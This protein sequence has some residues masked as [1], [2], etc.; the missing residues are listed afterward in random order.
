MRTLGSLA[1]A[2]LGT[3]AFG[4][5]ADLA[6]RAL[7]RAEP[8]ESFLSAGLF[9]LIAGVVFFFALAMRGATWAIVL[10][11]GISTALAALLALFDEPHGWII[12]AS[13]LALTFI[14]AALGRHRTRRRKLD[15]PIRS[16]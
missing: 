5:A 2:V 15:N 8:S 14:M 7:T 13:T 9:F 16:G 1:L 4:S 6:A 11:C 12:T 10:P 3:L